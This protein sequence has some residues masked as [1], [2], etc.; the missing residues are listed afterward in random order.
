MSNE[1]LDITIFIVAS[2]NINNSYPAIFCFVLKLLIT[3]FV[4]IM[5]HE[6][7]IFMTNIHTTV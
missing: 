6:D 1:Y 4:C 3:H 7:L 5:M 2:P